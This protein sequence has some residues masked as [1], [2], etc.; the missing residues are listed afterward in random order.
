VDRLS[1]ALLLVVGFTLPT[2]AEGEPD[3]SDWS[4]KGIRMGMTLEEA[5]TVHEFQEFTKYRDPTGYRRYV[6]Q[7]RDKPEKIEVHVDTRAQ[8]PRVIGV[9]TT[10]P[11]SEMNPGEFKTGLVEKWGRPQD[12][13][14]QGAFNLY[15]WVNT[16]C[17][18][19][20]RAS[21]M[22]EYH[23]V[24]VFMALTSLSGRDELAR[25][26][27]ALKEAEKTKEKARDADGDD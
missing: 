13:S 5:T 21:I 16:D 12:V 18:V 15:S 27:R 14:M 25:R 10:V 2:W 1:A 22:N 23:D 3:C 9:T 11:T 4:I 6:W 20:V 17:D 19:A 8:P 24:G 26:R 7:A